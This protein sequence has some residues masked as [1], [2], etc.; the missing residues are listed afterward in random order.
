MVAGTVVERRRFCNGVGPP[1][2]RDGGKA[3][4]SPDTLM[5]EPVMK[6]TAPLGA[7]LFGLTLAACEPLAPP[8]PTPVPTGCGAAEMQRHIGRPFVEAMIPPGAGP[9]RIGGPDT[10]MTM[11]YR[12]DRL[13]ILLD[14]AGRL[15]EAKCN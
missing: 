15:A 6:V 4:A 12:P 14:R 1:L 13:T 5:E 7:V 8:V 2:D 9:V 3:E 11:D 10:A